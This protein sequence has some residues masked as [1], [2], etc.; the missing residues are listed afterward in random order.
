MGKDKAHHSRRGR[1]RRKKLRVY[2]ND[3]VSDVIAT[4]ASGSAA[5]SRFG[6]FLKLC[7]WSDVVH[8]RQMPRRRL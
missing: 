7:T 2:L 8:I 3:A 1:R 4:A 6:V 5:R